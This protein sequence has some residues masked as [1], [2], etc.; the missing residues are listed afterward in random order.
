MFQ[1]RVSEVSVRGWLAPRFVGPWQ[2]RRCGGEC[3]VGKSCSPP[4]AGS[5]GE[6]WSGSSY[7]FK[8]MPSD[9]ASSHEAHLLTGSPSPCSYQ[10]GG[11]AFSTRVLG[12]ILH[13]W[14]QRLMCIS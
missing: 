4:G 5:K 8:D 1:L 13:P 3:T 6:E 11:Q 9:L 2:G 12:G 14:L 7:L 10:T